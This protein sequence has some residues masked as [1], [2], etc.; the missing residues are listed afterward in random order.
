M[1]GKIDLDTLPVDVANPRYLAANPDSVLFRAQGTK[2]DP[3]SSGAI[4]LTGFTIRRYRP[5][6]R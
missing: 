2:L 1:E 3:V 4:E 6:A 5:G